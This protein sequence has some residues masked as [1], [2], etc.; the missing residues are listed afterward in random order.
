MPNKT[1]LGAMLSAGMQKQPCNCPECRDD[2]KR[3]VREAIHES[4]QV[5]HN[6]LA[7]ISYGLKV[8][9]G[10]V[11]RLL[12]KFEEAEGT[13]RGSA[14]VINQ[15]SPAQNTAY[16]GN[17][18]AYDG[19]IR[20]MVLSGNG[21]VIVT[22]QNN[23]SLGGS[24]TIA[25]VSCNGGAVNVPLRHKMPINSTLSISTD[26]SSGTGIVALS[27]WIEPIKESNPE[28]FLLRR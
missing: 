21:N 25:V 2:V 10:V 19:V 27:A 26:S 23:L 16:V 18:L 22:L 20:S 28:Y 3:Q 15:G 9:V 17:A 8:L 12:N 4:N 5:T 14:Y 11:Q 1:P 6:H 7:E 13:P 24:T